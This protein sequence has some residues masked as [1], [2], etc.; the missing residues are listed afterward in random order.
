MKR[1]RFSALRVSVLSALLLNLAVP[2]FAQEEDMHS[3]ATE[4]ISLQVGDIFEILPVHDIPDATYTWILTQDRT[5]LEASRA[6][7]FRKRLIQPGTYTLYAEISSPDGSR[8]VSRTVTLDYAARNPSAPQTTV[9]TGTGNILVQTDPP[10]TAGGK[11]AMTADRQLV[12]LTPVNPD[13][14]PLALDLDL[15]RD[16]DG[17][18]NTANDIQS[19]DTFFHTDATP[20]YLWITD[21]PLTTHSISIT[22]ALPEGARTQALDILS[23]DIARAQGAVQSP[24]HIETQQT[25]ERTY[26]FTAAFDNPDAAAGQLLY[27]WQFGDGQQSLVTH[28]EHTYAE[29]ATYTVSLLVRNLRDGSEVASTS[30]VLN[31]TASNASSVS[32]EQ[33]S[34]ASST[35]STGGSGFSLGGIGRILML[36]GIFLG[37]LLLGVLAIFII[38]KLRKGK[39]SLADRLENME[40][41]MVKSPTQE[42]PAP[43]VIA[44][45]VMPAAETKRAEPPPSIAQREQEKAVERPAPQPTPKAE[46]TPS[47]L[48]T[49][50]VKPAPTPAPAA[51]APAQKPASAPVQPAPAPAPKPAA[52]PAQ[53]PSWLQ[54]PSAPPAA[55][56]AAPVPAS[57]PAPTVAQT[58]KPAPAQPATPAWLQQPA[59]PATP[60]PTAPAQPAAAPAPKPVTP[61]AAPVPQQPAPTP[62]PTSVQTPKP[63]PVPAPK[64]V[65]TPAPAPSAPVAPAAP[66]QTQPAP[67]APAVPAPEQKPAIAEAEP[68]PSKAEGAGRPAV[69]DIPVDQPIAI[70][71]AESLNP[72]NPE[73]QQNG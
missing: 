33:T 2:A 50:A 24:V 22:A 30:T 6:P 52:A 35:P 40:K 26:T 28:A 61:P 32:S 54:Q 15:S 44:P 69:M 66:T 53:T 36:V 56:P 5:F 62:T 9:T 63:A 73:N 1:L 34:S 45:P 41:T 29:D 48:N 18:G 13:I 14:T 43:L 25:G 64:P 37:S 19:N 57:V 59:T 42:S 38:G 46:N 3:A 51:P 10:A 65:Q 12:R 49:P 16:A 20:L 58:P 31:V 71:K 7:S 39:S 55:K 68:V 60:K 23:E 17:D 27:Q 8:R 72:Q 11:I 4:Q 67:I 70:I 21:E 47:W